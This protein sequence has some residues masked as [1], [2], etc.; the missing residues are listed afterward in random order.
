MTLTETTSKEI[1]DILSAVYQIVEEEIEID[2][3]PYSVWTGDVTPEEERILSRLR[4]ALRGAMSEVDH[5][6]L[7]QSWE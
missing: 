1:Y 2:G 6:R 4:K 3:I 7:T 5:Y